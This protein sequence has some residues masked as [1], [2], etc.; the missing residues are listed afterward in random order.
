MNSAEILVV[1]DE[2]QIQKLLQ[3]SLESNGF[4]VT[5][6]ETGKLGLKLCAMNAPSLILLDIGLPD[7][8]GHAVLKELRSWYEKPIIILSV[9]ESEDDI[10]RALDNGATD[11]LTK[12]FR[13]RELLARIRSCLRRSEL[14]SSEPVYVHGNLHIDFSAHSIKKNDEPV[15]FTLK[16]YNILVLLVKNE[17]RVLTHQ[18]ILREVWG[19]GH[20]Q[21]TQY[22]RVFIAALRKK[23][24]D[25]PNHPQFIVT[26]SG[27]G[28][29][30]Q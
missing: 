10:V 14:S 7:M 20:Q 17:G 22:L 16:E 1:D 26:E 29:R 12:P 30:F 19:I 11:Y 6:A 25:D 18:H 4:K 5:Q 9:I 3:I 15:K 28:Y 27:I 21:E 8:S 24:E 13:T 23:I 2:P